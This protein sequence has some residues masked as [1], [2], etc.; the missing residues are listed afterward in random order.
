MHDYYNR[1]EIVFKENSRLTLVPESTKV[2][3]KPI[4]INVLDEDRSETAFHYL[5][6]SITAIYIYYPIWWPLVMFNISELE[7]E[8]NINKTECMLEPCH[9]LSNFDFEWAYWYLSNWESLYW[10]IQKEK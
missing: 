3:F 10:R 5:S 1:V 8:K 6:L 9:F 4:F 7:D 2:V